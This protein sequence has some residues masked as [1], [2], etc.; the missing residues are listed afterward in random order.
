MA[1]LA[2][3]GNDLSEH[4]LHFSHAGLVLRD[5]PS[6]RWRIWHLLNR[7]GTDDAGL[8]V[9][10]LFHYFAGHL[11]RQDAKIVFLEPR[12][13]QELLS[14]L[15]DG[16]AQRL[17]DPRYNVLARPGSPRTQNSTAYL[18]EWLATA[19]HGLTSGHRADAWRELA[20][21]FSPDRIHVAWGK[22]VLAG[23]AMQNVDFTDHS[24][25]TRLRGDYPVVTVRS[26]LRYL[27]QRQLATGAVLVR[28]GRTEEVPVSQ[29]RPV[30]H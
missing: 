25:A 18:L 7:C 26:I 5:H 16:R 23:V 3:V 12:L 4:G 8:H 24:V 15:A 20:P 29:D 10:G 2:R 1:L 17:F 30:L 27:Q 6:G 19:E 9:E 13:E 14:T 21:E 11:T 28:K 22:R